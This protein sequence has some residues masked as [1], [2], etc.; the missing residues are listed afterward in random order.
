[1]K[2]PRLFYILFF[3]DCIA[4]LA[5]GLYLQHVDGLEP[6]PL[7][8]FQR[9]AYIGV[10]LVAIAAAIQGPGLL[11][12]RIY[13]GLIT[14]TSMVGAGIAGRQVWLQHLPA[15][16]VPACGPDLEYM[17]EV[18]TFSETLKNVFTGS[19]ECAE[20]DWTFLGL[21]IAEW[22]LICFVIYAIVALVHCIR[23][24]LLPAGSWLD[25]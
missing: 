3:L 22:S 7:C 9:W 5:Y 8:I 6:C 17:L 20:V 19:G 15:D 11:G 18:F 24:R 21:S 14:L 25:I 16:Q 10:A 4:L 2:A 13:S 23:G 12:I 1:M